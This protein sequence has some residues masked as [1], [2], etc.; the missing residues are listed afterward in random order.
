MLEICSL[1][2]QINTFICM[3]LG[4]TKLRD[5]YFVL[6]LQINAAYGTLVRNNSV[7]CIDPDLQW[8]YRSDSTIQYNASNVCELDYASAVCDRL[9]LGARRLIKIILYD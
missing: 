4:N 9:L 5:L 7:L 8:A 2:R 1:R 3:D 6:D